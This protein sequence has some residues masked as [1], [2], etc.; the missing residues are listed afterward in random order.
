MRVNAGVSIVS[1]LV[2][3][4]ACVDLGNLTGGAPGPRLSPSADS[5][6]GDA[7]ELAVVPV[8]DGGLDAHRDTCI[9][10]SPAACTER[11]CHFVEAWSGA[12]GTLWPS[13][14]R[15]E[16]RVAGSGVPD[17]FAGWGRIETGQDGTYELYASLPTATEVEQVVTFSGRRASSHFALFCRASPGFRY[18]LDLR[19]DIALAQ[20]LRIVDPLGGNRVV[21]SLPLVES[22][23]DYRVRFVCE[24]VRAGITQLRVRLWRA[25]EPEPIADTVSWMDENPGLDGPGAFGM[26]IDHYSGTRFLFDDYEVT[27]R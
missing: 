1:I 7:T 23:V 2:T 6:L 24:H 11:G 22:D 3:T 21:R 15:F 25:T 17:I 16:G 8:A 19:L 26:R 10:P 13:H 27:F 18:E 14:W 12:D 4:A 9:C 20:G 5:G